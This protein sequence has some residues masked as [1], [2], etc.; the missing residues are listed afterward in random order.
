MATKSKTFAGDGQVEEHLQFKLLASKV[1]S[2]SCL[3]HFYRRDDFGPNDEQSWHIRLTLYI[4]QLTGRLYFP[5]SRAQVNILWSFRA[6]D[7]RQIS[8]PDFLVSLL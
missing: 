2:W 8:G 1:E 7:S 6:N 4:R 3:W 5:A